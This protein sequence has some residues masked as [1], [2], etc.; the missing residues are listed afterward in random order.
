M[1]EENTNKLE[2]FTICPYEKRS[3]IHNKNPHNNYMHIKTIKC[4][5]HTT[6]TLVKA[7]LI[8]LKCSQYPSMMEI[9]FFL[10]VLSI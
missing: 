5:K 9:H 2:N 1:H 6:F 10:I 8:D 7:L 3:Y 4:G